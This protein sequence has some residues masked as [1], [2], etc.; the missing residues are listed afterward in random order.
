MTTTAKGSIGAV[1]TPTESMKTRRP[2]SLRISA[3][4]IGERIELRVQAKSTLPGNRAIRLT[5]DMQDAE[6]RKEPPRR[7]VVHYDAIGEPLGQ[8]FAAFI[9]QP[10]PA[11][12]DRLDLGRARLAHGAVIAA[13]DDEIIFDQLAE[14]QKRQHH[15]LER[16]VLRVTDIELE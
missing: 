14:G 10:A 9:V 2:C 13:A 6:Q 4:A 12:I 5:S 16:P 7:V 8:F 1:R 3:A 11:H 15:V